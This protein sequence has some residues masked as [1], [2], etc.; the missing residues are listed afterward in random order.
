[1]MLPTTWQFIKRY[2]YLFPFLVLVLL[3]VAIGHVCR[4]L[5]QTWAWLKGQLV[6]DEEM[7]RRLDLVD[8]DIA[9]RLNDVAEMAEV[10]HP[11]RDCTIEG[12]NQACGALERWELQY[13]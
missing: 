7:S 6:A 13:G 1:M 9:R 5:S 8:E 4:I 3:L 2:P 11:C 12:C 10:V